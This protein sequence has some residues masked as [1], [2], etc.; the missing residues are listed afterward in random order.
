M[1]HAGLEELIMHAG[2]EKRVLVS[3]SRQF[4]CTLL[5]QQGNQTG[6]QYPLG[7][8][9]HHKSLGIRMATFDSLKS[10]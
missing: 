1:Q 3:E 7:F 2:S 6:A 9:L 4:Q 10:I 5:Y 8:F